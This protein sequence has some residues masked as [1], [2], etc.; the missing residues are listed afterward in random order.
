M[1]FM[2][3]V[4]AAPPG[5]GE[6][7][8]NPGN[9]VDTLTVRYNISNLM[10]EPIINGTYRWESSTIESLPEDTA[11][12]LKIQSYTNP[13]N[14]AFIK[15]DP[16]PGDRGEWAQ[17]FAG[18]PNWDKTL[19]LSYED[20]NTLVYADARAAKQFWIGGFKVIDAFLSGSNSVS[21]P[22]AGSATGANQDNFVEKFKNGKIK[23]RSWKGDYLHRP[24]SVQGVTTWHTGIGNEWT[25]V[26][27]NNGKVAL[28]S[29]KGDYLHRPDSVQ[30]VT[31][32]NT[33]IGNEWTL[34]QLNNGKVALRSWKGDYLHRPD[35]VQG[36][37]TW[38][39][40]IGNEWTI[41]PVN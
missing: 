20:N 30:G 33:G 41:E 7:T 19:T 16:A 9:E 1:T 5:R 32:W 8:V 37:T 40:G 14:Y 17:N 34:V 3:S 23:L 18:S 29:W 35:S 2:T 22:A 10:G 26:P 11:V 25:L 36:V 28:R 24:D 15:L 31:T 39:T 27:L 13:P 4:F 6:I 38:N 21:A 12:W